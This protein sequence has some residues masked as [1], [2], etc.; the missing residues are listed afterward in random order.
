[1][2]TIQ[3]Q[4][5][6]VAYPIHF[7]SGC[8][9]NPTD[10]ASLLQKNNVFSKAHQALIIT[11][12]NVGPL[13][14]THLKSAL[15]K[16]DIN[17]QILVLPAGETTKNWNSAQQIFESAMDL[18]L[19]RHDMVIALG[20]GVIGDLAGFCA[21]TYHRGTP[22]IQIP[23]TLLAQVDSSVGGKVAIHVGG[24]KNS[25]G[26]FYHPKAVIIDSNVLSTLPKREWRAGMA[27]VVKYSLLES[28]ISPQAEP[29]F[30]NTLEKASYT[31]GFKPE[32]TPI[33]WLTHCC[34]L[35]QAVVQ[36][37]ET[38]QSGFRMIL[39]LGHTYAHILES[40]T[41]YTRFLHG[42]AVALGLIAACRQST[43]QGLLPETQ[44]QRVVDLLTRIGLPTSLPPDIELDT[45][46]ALRWLRK[47]KKN[48]S[49]FPD[50]ILP[51]HT[52]GTVARSSLQNEAEACNVIANWLQFK[53]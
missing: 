47:D 52:I 41:Q 37:D 50:L 11:D 9:T 3:H 8:V 44:T 17:T 27:E 15:K 39:N 12:E 1:M 29:S 22:Y 35:K 40:A 31:E 28:T 20:G 34:K 51:Q 43:L 10:L 18:N 4:Q 49:T 21:A 45:P 42:E 6:S 36:A 38:E 26:A 5:T 32:D 7:E 30:F 14:Q 53:S 46:T 19:T 2:L 48:R 23:T 13:Y 33:E 24:V 25:V 16:I